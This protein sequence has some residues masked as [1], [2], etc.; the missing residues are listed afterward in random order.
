MHEFSTLALTRRSIRK[1]Q[2]QDIPLR[3]IEEFIKIAASAPSGCN[4]QCWKFI[5][6][7]DKMILNQIVEAAMEKI[8]EMT[9]TLK[10]EPSEEYLISKHKAL[11]FF[12]KAPVVIGVFMTGYQYYDPVLESAIK[13]QGF[14]DE[15]MM[16]LFGHP[17][18]LSVG[19]AVENLLLAVHAKGYG[20][21]WMNE[22]AIAGVA[23]NKIL[24]MPLDYEFMSLIPIGI[25]AYTPREK[26]MK[27]F[28][29]IFSRY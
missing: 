7:K 29:E 17:D 5:A 16:K 1:Y 19:A 11:S 25:P 26:K 9:S 21:C 23:I 4:S 15:A 6:I 3:E 10:P 27:E 2:D 8:L 14:R 22:A 24:K 18:I 13:A 28:K 12:V 20:A